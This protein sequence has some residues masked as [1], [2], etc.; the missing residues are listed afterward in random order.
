MRLGVPILKHF[1]VCA[2]GKTKKKRMKK[3]KITT[4]AL[5][6]LHFVC[7]KIFH[8]LTVYSVYFSVTD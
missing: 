1:R 5:K 6:Y 8:S 7:L 3:N 2:I 4:S